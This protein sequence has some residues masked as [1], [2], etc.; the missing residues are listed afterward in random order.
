MIEGTYRI[1]SSISAPALRIVLETRMRT[2]KED[3]TRLRERRG[4]PSIARPMGPLVWAHAASVGESLSVLPLLSAFLH[5]QPAW[6]ALLTTGTWTSAQVITERLQHADLQR[7]S[8]QFLPLDHPRWGHRFLEYWRPSAAIWTESDFWPNMLATCRMRQIPMALVNGRLSPRSFARWQWAPQ[9]IRTILS[10]FTVCL[11]QSP[12]DTERLQALGSPKAQYVGNLKHAAPPLPVNEKD[13]TTVKDMTAGRPL[14]LAAS[15]HEGEERIAA[16]VHCHIR[17]NLPNLLTVISPR[18][19]SRGQ[20]V[21]RMLQQRG[22]RVACR[23]HGDVP[24][25][26][27]DVWLVDTVGELGLFYRTCPV[28]FVGKSLHKGGGQNPLEA[29]RL[30]SIVIAGPHVSTFRNIY[31][32]MAHCGSMVA[33]QTA[34]DLAPAVHHILTDSDT[35]QDVAQKALEFC[36]NKESVL[37]QTLAHLTPLVQGGSV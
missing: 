5:T 30:G 37:D 16:D 6:S 36:K 15:T 25:H 21:L 2:G 8:H 22:L 1:L 34:S 24:T 10:G 31:D 7:I 19:P 20:N 11:G 28:S 3:P 17:Q 4:Y 18:H 27:H 23:S 12:E 33:I 29:A 32:Q 9:M 14:W 13:L 26:E 35:R